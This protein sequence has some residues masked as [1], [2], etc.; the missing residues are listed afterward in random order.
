MPSAPAARTTPRVRIVR[1]P[2][3]ILRVE[4]RVET[5]HPPWPSSSRPVDQGLGADLGAEPLGEPEVVL[6]E[7]VLG[8]VPAPHHAAAAVGAGGA[9]R[10]L[11]AEEGVPHLLAGPLAEEDGDLGGAEGLLAADRPREVLEGA[12]PLPEV[13]GGVDAQHPLGG[14]VVGGERP[15]PVDPLGPGAALERAVL[16]HEVGAGVDQRAAADPRPREHQHVAQQGQPLDAV[17]E[18]GGHPEE[19]PHASSSSSGNP[20]SASACRPPAPAPCTPSRRAAAP[21]RCRRSRSRRSRSRS[22]DLRRKQDRLTRGMLAENLPWVPFLP[23]LRR[24]LRQVAAKR[25]EGE[26]G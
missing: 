20:A 1:L 4:L 5:R 23:L 15:L 16:G 12:V 2:R 11:A 25:D 10:P 9:V 22:R 8:A 26:A 18:Q 6:V 24:S 14:P 7:G 3:K 21:R 17:A 13:G 19:L